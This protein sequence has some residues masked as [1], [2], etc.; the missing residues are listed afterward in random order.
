M[1]WLAIIVVAI[2]A[3]VVYRAKK[4]KADDQPLT[5]ADVQTEFKSEVKSVLDVNG[6]GV[7]NV[8]DVVAAGKKVKAGAK[9]AAGKAKTAAKKAKSKLRVAK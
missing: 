4:N 8:A 1:L 7:V 5:I 9:K 6:D 2:I 3:I